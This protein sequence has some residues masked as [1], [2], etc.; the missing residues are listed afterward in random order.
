MAGFAQTQHT[1]QDKEGTTYSVRFVHLDDGW[2]LRL[3]L[4]E[5]EVG[6]ANCEFHGASL[7][8]GNIEIYG[9]AAPPVATTGATEPQPAA[10]QPPP[11]HYRGRGAGAAFLQLIIEQARLDGFREI[12]GNLL[13]QNLKD[14]PGLPDWYRRRGFDVRMNPDGRGGA[15]RLKLAPDGNEPEGTR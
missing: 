9:M 1:I 14:W 10:N 6:E 12:R 3:L 5:R 4:Q 7:Y 8:L 13:P 2:D 11:Q 15:I